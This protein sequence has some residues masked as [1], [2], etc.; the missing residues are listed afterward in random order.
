MPYIKMPVVIFHGTP[1]IV[2]SQSFYI[3]LV[4]VCELSRFFVQKINPCIV[5]CKPEITLFVVGNTGNTIAAYT[6][7]AVVASIV[8]KFV[9]IIIIS[10]HSIP[11]GSYPDDV[12]MF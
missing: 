3:R 5:S 9:F 7:L 12:I 11:L 8:G 6:V 10:I 1:I 2:T 4:I